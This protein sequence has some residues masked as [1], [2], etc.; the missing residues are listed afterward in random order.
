M[1]DEDRDRAFIE[2]VRAQLDASLED[3]D[4]EVRRRLHRARMRALEEEE[5]RRRP[6]WDLLRIPALGM[7]AA[8]IL[9]IAFLTYMGGPSK[10]QSIAQVENV[11]LF[12]SKESL[13]LLVNLDFYLWL[14]EEE[15]NDVG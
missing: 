3:V 8:A 7:A 15:E 12:A 14:S 1:N 5:V 10:D 4:E 9:L 13:E 11:E 2:G 6:V